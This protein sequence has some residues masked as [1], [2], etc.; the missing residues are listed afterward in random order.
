MALPGL[1]PIYP[2]PIPLKYQVSLSLPPL[3]IS[4][5]SQEIGVTASSLFLV[6]NVEFIQK[7]IEGDIGI[8]DKILKEAM[9]KTFNNPIAQKDEKVFTKFAEISKAKVPDVNT[10]RS[11]GKLKLPKDK[12]AL[13][14]MEG[15]GF[16][17][18]EKTILT[19]IFE[20]QKPYFEVAKL[21][22]GNIAKIEDIIARV[23]PL[24]GIPLVTKSLKPISNGGAGNRP[25]AIGYQGGKELKDALAKLKQLSKSGGTNI[26]IGKDGKA[27]REKIVPSDKGAT[28]SQANVSGGA[29]DN[30]NWEVVS[31][32]YSTGRFIPEVEYKYTYIDLPPTEKLKEEQP[33]LN[34]ENDDPY[35]KHKPEKIILGIFKS[36]GTPL[37]PL[38]KLKTVSVNSNGQVVYLDTPFSK[39]DWILN[40]SKWQMDNIFPNKKPNNSS[41]VPKSF[42]SLGS[43]IYKW[44]KGIFSQDS[45]TKPG[46]GY[47][48]KK[49]GSNRKSLLDPEVDAIEGD[50]MIVGFD[51]LESNEYKSY[52]T[53]IVRYKMYQSEDLEQSEKNQLTND[54]V[55]QLNI[56]SHLA[57]VFQYGQARSSVYKP[58][59]GKPAFPENMKYSFKPF[60]LYSA[61]AESDEKL[62]AYNKSQGKPAG[63]IWID[64]ESDYET[65]VIRVDPT[66][67]IE[68]SEAQGQPVIKSTIKSF[69]KNKL[70]ISLS[71]G[72]LMGIEIS[73][74]NGTPEVFENVSTYVLDNWNYNPDVT[75]SPQQ[76]IQ[77]TNAYQIS[78]WSKYPTRTYE[79]AT[80]PIRIYNG[81]QPID[82]NSLL[83]SNN[84][85]FEV[86]DFEY[87]NGRR[88]YRR[89]KYI[90]NIVPLQ[91]GKFLGINV[92]G[93]LKDLFQKFENNKNTS[94]DTIFRARV[95]FTNKTVGENYSGEDNSTITDVYNSI[96]KAIS[97]ANY[98]LIDI[99]SKRKLSFTY[100]GTAYN[101]ELRID[102]LIKKVVSIVPENNT[103]Y[104]KLLQE[105]S[106]FEYKF[107]LQLSDIF[108]QKIPIKLPDGVHLLKDSF[109]T[110]VQLKNEEIIRWYYIYNHSL[111]NPNSVVPTIANI[112]QFSLPPFGKEYKITINHNSDP[113]ATSKNLQVSRQEVNILQYNIQ[114][115]G[116]GF[117]YG[118][119]I[120][121]SRVANQVLATNELYSKGKYG[122]GS[123]DSPQEIEVI[124]R[125]MLTDL[126]TESYFIIEG[127][128]TDKNKQTDGVSSGTGASSG[129]ASGDGYYK[130]PHALGAIKVFLSLA[131]DIAVKLIPLMAKIISLFKN[132]ASFVTEIIKEKMGQGFSIFS[133]ESFETFEAAQ[134]E[135]EKLKTAKPSER[136]RTMKGI[137]SGSP[138]SNHV[139]VNSKGDFKFLLDG[140]ALLPFQIFG[141]QLPFGM[142]L[143]F[144]NIPSSPIN[145]IFKE[146]LKTSKV[147]N[148]QSFLNKSLKDFKGPGSD[149]LASGLNV[150]DLKSIKDEPIY[151]VPKKPIDYNNPNNF[152]VIDIKYSTGTFI[153]GIDYNYI[154]INQD[155]ENVIKSAQQVVETPDEALDV[156]D[157]Q[158]SIEE[159]ED[160]LKKDPNNKALKDMLK[161]LKNKLRGINDTSQPLL[162]MLLGFVTLPIKIIGGIIE[163]LMKFF[164]SLTN[165]LTLPAKIV[166]LLSFSWLMKFFTPLGILELAG[167]KFEP[168]KIL[169][170][171]ALANVP[172]VL[173]PP[174]AVPEIPQGVNL[175]ELKYYKDA[176]PK[177]RYLIPDDYE[178]VDWDQI[179][180][181]PFLPK[182][183]TYTARQHREMCGRPI[184]LVMPTLCL[185]EKVI[186]GI[187]DFIW[188]V[189]GI[190]PLIPAPHIKLC[191][192]SAD[193]DVYDL[194][195][196][197]DDLA[198]DSGLTAS[199][200]SGVKEND[201]PADAGFVYD[202]TLDDGT[203]VK[204]LNYEQMQEYIKKHEDIGYDFQF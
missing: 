95:F 93:N 102:E 20:T 103:L 3:P 91:V 130:L 46:D 145:L 185:I 27:V 72:Q 118:K 201:L 65:K 85:S 40:S 128:L 47:E 175:P 88:Y 112:N 196:I 44:E 90:P 34:L 158:K 152:E 143:N 12:V 62:A 160:A 31:A 57:N 114:V 110:R 81:V 41:S 33:D 67:K 13:E 126:D 166:E 37:D 69:V 202:I 132:P 21:V 186:N 140:L 108:N 177:G 120:D 15:V 111:F 173:K 129:Q 107:I 104:Y 115:T 59:N 172:N 87:S 106:K 8:S 199:I 30:V 193:P 73:K 168:R 98:G 25:K 169:E 188:S 52:F 35:D 38:E 54:I 124:K 161:N 171:C 26:K 50:P 142:E 29:S 51:S 82:I 63:Y 39:A 14:P 86:Y 1:F 89:Y 162:K 203:V 190:E 135:K 123:T 99:N 155:T 119:V 141:L 101:L 164:K 174:A 58:V 84:S 68:F 97:F 163:W 197:A 178:L 139:F 53:D 36:D 138:L 60:Q 187:I 176:A 189:L 11:G 77:N 78:I 109:G 56:Q 100:N 136:E 10:L 204:G 146:N 66:T 170:W 156:K 147:K 191:S 113:D 6:P 133:K 75:L 23:M 198:K 184:K 195:K 116:E 55:S 154:Y 7:F 5:I 9:F 157:A 94:I 167:V 134:Q 64:P 122:H 165:P 49:Y 74:N 28:Q 192:K 19:S 121:P 4:K 182:L 131:V 180:S 2:D 125:Y 137:F 151:N 71:N 200:P 96:N 117:P 18:L 183:P 80:T 181:M 159:V 17:G 70:S 43:P 22:I 83:T 45:K 24:L 194:I 32:V 42:P 153:N 127:I 61:S 149:G 105:I 150:S 92:A 48:I 79:K 76:R 16:K 144:A 179:L 148:M